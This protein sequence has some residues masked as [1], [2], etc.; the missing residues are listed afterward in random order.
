MTI[1]LTGSD[2][3]SIN[4]LQ[5]LESSE[6]QSLIVKEGFVFIRI[7][8]DS[9]EHAYFTRICKNTRNTLLIQY[10]SLT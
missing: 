4:L 3:D 6:V 7:E 2:A 5:A 9:P 10:D 1:N 8:A